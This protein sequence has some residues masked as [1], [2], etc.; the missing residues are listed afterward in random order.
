LVDSPGKSAI[1]KSPTSIFP[2]PIQDAGFF[3]LH[4]KIS[5]RSVVVAGIRVSQRV[6]RKFWDYPAR[7]A[8]S[9]QDVARRLFGWILLNKSKIQVTKQE[10][11][12]FL[13]LSAVAFTGLVLDLSLKGRREIFANFHII[14]DPSFYPKI[15][16]NKATQ[17]ELVA[18]PYLGPVTARMIIEHRPFRNLEELKA[19]PGIREGNYRRMEK[20]LKVK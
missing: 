14:D 1:I 9:L 7:V 6:L 11:Q 20:Y 13:F 18:V 10:R 4:P 8:T 15:N 17:D 12:V 5:L 3:M 19:L 16:I 2:A